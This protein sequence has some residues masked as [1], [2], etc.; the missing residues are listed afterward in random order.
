MSRMSSVLHFLQAFFFFYPLQMSVI[1]ICISQ[2]LVGFSIGSWFFICHQIRLGSFFQTVFPFLPL[3]FF[4]H[5]LFRFSSFSSMSHVYAKPH[6]AKA[7][8]AK[9]FDENEIIQ[10]WV[11]SFGITQLTRAE[12]TRSFIA[13][14]CTQ[15]TGRSFI[16]LWRSKTTNI[17]NS[18]DHCFPTLVPQTSSRGAMAEWQTIKL[19]LLFQCKKW[20]T[21]DYDYWETPVTISKI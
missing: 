19:V 6:L 4:Q 8:F 14:H 9:N 5:N 3:L 1:L 7:S 11:H 12:G 20:K 2:I 13:N 21:T 10:H 16:F 18:L 15:L 17:S